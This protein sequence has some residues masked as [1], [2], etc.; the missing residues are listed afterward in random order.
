MTAMIEALSFLGPHGPVARDVESCVF[1][2]SK[3]ASGVCLGTI[4][5]RTHVQ[6][7]LAC[8]LPRRA[9][10]NVSSITCGISF[11]N[12][13]VSSRQAACLFFS[14]KKSNWAKLHSLV[15][16]PLIYFAT[17]KVLMILHDATMGTI[18]HGVFL[19]V[20]HHCHPCPST[21]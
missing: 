14:S 18:A 12:C 19:V 21:C 10:V 1:V 9:L 3:Y 17:G 11:W 15:I 16:L 7:A 20:R 4:Q 8:L 2:D 5:A 13:S 6:L